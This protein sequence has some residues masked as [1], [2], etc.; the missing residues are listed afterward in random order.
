VVVQAGEKKELAWDRKQQ[1]MVTG[2]WMTSVFAARV[3]FLH[4]QRIACP[5]HP[6]WL[7]EHTQMARA[8]VYNKHMSGHN[9]TV[10]RVAHGAQQVLGTHHD[11][12]V[13]Q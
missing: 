2:P 8:K 6:C 12:L 3:P 10:F 1:D 4:M 5:T 9:E 7:C 13:V 11:W